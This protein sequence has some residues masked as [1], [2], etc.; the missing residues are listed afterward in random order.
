MSYL[1]YMIV[2]FSYYNLK[3]IGNIF[4]SV[5][6]SM[7]VMA[8]DI[9]VESK[10]RLHSDCS[11]TD[12]ITLRPVA[13]HEGFMR[14]NTKFLKRH[15]ERL[16]RRLALTRFIEGNGNIKEVMKINITKP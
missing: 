5:I 9:T 4:Q 14:L 10:R 13:Y 1:R 16:L 15:T 11:R 2:R 3:Q 6:R 8:C 12:N 7:L